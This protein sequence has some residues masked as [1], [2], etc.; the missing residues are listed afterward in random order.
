M[1][2][3][4]C[5]KHHLLSLP[6]VTA[7]QLTISKK[8]YHQLRLNDP[9]FCESHLVSFAPPPPSRPTYSIYTVGVAYPSNKAYRHIKSHFGARNRVPRP[10]VET[11][12]H[13]YA[14]SDLLTGEMDPVA[15][16]RHGV[17]ATALTPS[18]NPG[19]PKPHEIANWIPAGGAML[20]R[21]MGSWQRGLFPRPT[22][23]VCVAPDHSNATSDDEEQ[24]HALLEFRADPE[25]SLMRRVKEKLGFLS[26]KRRAEIYKEYLERQREEIELDH[27]RELEGLN[28]FD[29][30]AMWEQDEQAA[31]DDDEA[32]AVPNADYGYVPA[33]PTLSEGDLWSEY[34]ECYYSMTIADRNKFAEA[35]AWYGYNLALHVKWFAIRQ[36]EAETVKNGEATPDNPNAPVFPL[37]PAA[38]VAL[39]DHKPHVLRA[40]GVLPWG[41]HFMSTVH[42]A[43]LVIS[44]A[45]EVARLAAA[46][47]K[48]QAQTAA[49]AAAALPPARILADLDEAFRLMEEVGDTLVAAEKMTAEWL[50]RA[51]RARIFYPDT[52]ELTDFEEESVPE[53]WFP[54]EAEEEKPEKKGKGKKKKKGKKGK[55]AKGE[56]EGEEKAQG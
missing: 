38:N 11:W 12:I 36:E 51:V 14:T 4:I 54:P 43:A 56:G 28:A 7:Q 33:R 32:V 21:E 48:E 3:F 42:L 35:L 47:A 49:A 30:T 24:Y 40:F 31:A 18:T 27:L 26:K 6:S 45:K 16:V 23:S 9:D 46:E 2:S 17:D 20:D 55:K 50:S 29:A 52:D 22:E 5:L 10:Q 34:W 15:L 44:T 19:A 53:E 37:N 13:H 25:A 1:S 41:N 8:Q 39:G